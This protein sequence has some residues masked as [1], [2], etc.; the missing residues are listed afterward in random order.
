MEIK[1]GSPHSKITSP[2]DA[3][4]IYKFLDVYKD[5]QYNMND[6]QKT[7][8]QKILSD[9]TTLQTE[10]FLE[11]Q[12]ETIV[13]LLSDENCAFGEIKIWGRWWNGKEDNAG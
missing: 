1:H 7:C 12:E 13:T 9:D 2:T 8:I 3:I 10:G 11:A 4:E 6:L 5:Q